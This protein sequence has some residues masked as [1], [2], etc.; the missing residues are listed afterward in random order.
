MEKAISHPFMLFIEL[1][2]SND[3]I[4]SDMTMYI[5]HVPMVRCCTLWTESA[6]DTVD[7]LQAVGIKYL[8]VYIILGPHARR[9]N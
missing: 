7:Q 5:S 2:E 9:R 3:D 6:M 8:F 1:F 4:A